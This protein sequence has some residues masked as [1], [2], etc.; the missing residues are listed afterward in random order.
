MSNIGEAPKP[1][2]WIITIERRD[3]SFAQK[4]I[5]AQGETLSEASENAEEKEGDF[6][7]VVAG[8]ILR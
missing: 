3:G 6:W 1:K 7:F 4:K 8:R 2:S 5:H